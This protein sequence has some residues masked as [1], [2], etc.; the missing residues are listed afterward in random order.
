M[1]ASLDKNIG[2]SS[3]L[4]HRDNEKEFKQK[5]IEVEGIRLDTFMEKRNISK[6]DLLC[7]DL[8]GAEYLA[9]EG[10]GKRIK[11]VHYLITEVAFR[12][13]YHKDKL[14]EDIVRLLDHRGFKFISSNHDI[15]SHSGFGDALFLNKNYGLD[16]R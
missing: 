9:I 7:M 14:A 6:V 15:N 4:W 8:Q 12:S 3:L 13:F 10:L 1:E 5:R 16:T 2:A 11:D